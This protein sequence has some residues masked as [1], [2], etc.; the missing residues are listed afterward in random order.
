MQ[1][2]RCG[3]LYSIELNHTLQHRTRRRDERAPPYP[4]H[5]PV[6]RASDLAATRGKHSG[7]TSQRQGPDQT[8]ETLESGRRQCLFFL[9]LYAAGFIQ[10]N[11]IYKWKKHSI[12]C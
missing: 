10:A 6:R 5:H 3:C 1:Y 11:D 2:V 9:L 12:C 8:P 4:N 7:G